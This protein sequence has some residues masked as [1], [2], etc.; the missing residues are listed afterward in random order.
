MLAVDNK[1]YKTPASAYEN[2]GLCALDNADTEKASSYFNEA[3]KINANMPRSLFEMAKLNY[4]KKSFSKA[5]QYLKRFHK[6]NKPLS[7][8]LWLSF[9]IESALGH[10]QNAQKSLKQL[11]V[12]FPNSMEAAKAPESFTV[13][14]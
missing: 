4:N 1:M 7:Q 5:Q 6:L 8:S 9:Q 14:Q 13:D 10:H 2:A 11:K 12:D 3:L